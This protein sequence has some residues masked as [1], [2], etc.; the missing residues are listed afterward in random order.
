[1]EILEATVDLQKAAVKYIKLKEI[2]DEE[3]IR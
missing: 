1:M 2:Y 3:P